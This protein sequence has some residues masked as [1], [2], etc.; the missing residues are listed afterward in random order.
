MMKKRLFLLFLTIV[1]ASL[2][3]S[4]CAKEEEPADL[5]LIQGKIVTMDEASPE[6]EALAVRG[7]TIL[8]IGTNAEIEPYIGEST[9]LIDLE[10]NLAIP[11]FIDAHA[12]FTGIGQAKM[13]LDLMQVNN[14][15]EVVA[16]VAEAV[17]RLQSGEWIRGRGWHQE[18]WNR[19]PEANVDG[20]PS[21]TG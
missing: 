1:C 7:D 19:V 3:P 12:H 4:G 13:E 16:L 2:L 18:K 8:A 5:V 20:L 6:A 9:R 11:G 17:K 10:G 15:D 21:I 14:W